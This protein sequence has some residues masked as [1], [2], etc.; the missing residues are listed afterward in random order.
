MEPIL[1]AIICILV[2]AGIAAFVIFRNKNAIIMDEGGENALSVKRKNALALS[3]K[4]E[5]TITFDDLPA[6][7]EQEESQ[8]VEV[9]DSQ[10]LARIDNAIP[11]T[12]Q[13]V[14]NTGAVHAYQEAAKSAGQLYQAIIPKGAVLDKSRAMEGAVRGSYRDVA[15]SI[16]GNANWVAVDGKAAKNLAA[17]GVANAA[18]NVASMVVGQYYMSQINDQLADINAGIEKVA[19][20]QQTEFKSKV[21]ALVAEVQKSSTFQ[22]ETIENDELRNRELSHLKSL[23]H[24]CAQL[25]GQ[26]NLSLQDISGKKGLNYD[27]YE[28]KIGEAEKWFQYQQILLE[29]MYKISDLSY[30][31][32]LG[33][34]SRENSYALYLPYA[35]QSEG[36][37]AKL[38]EWHDEHVKRLEINVEESRR[39]RQGV[40]GFF[41][42][43]LGLFND[44][45]NYK[46]MSQSTIARIGHQAE[47]ASTVKGAEEDDL[48]QEDVRLI[49]KDGKLYYLPKEEVVEK[50]GRGDYI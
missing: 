45:F 33:A 2:V 17:V 18:M 15:N 8:L 7:T 28:K 44:D 14:A 16:K 40:E 19:D 12:L 49:A 27:A 50:Q 9:K 47:H 42:G 5:L 13:A 6:L 34:I 24:E 37:L 30:A 46:K 41:M 36:T 29:V 39:K 4:H 48:Y 35:K 1:I 22:V 31:L 26:A 21:Y 3:K 38:N 10:L 20:F 11:G 25:L 32:N 23:E 43:A